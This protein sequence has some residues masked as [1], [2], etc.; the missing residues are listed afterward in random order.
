[1]SK[2]STPHSNAAVNGLAVLSIA[3]AVTLALVTAS[4]VRAQGQISS[5]KVALT[6]AT[7]QDRIDH[8]GYLRLTDEN[9]TQFI[10][11][12]D[13]QAQLARMQSLSGDC[14]NSA[15]VDATAGT[16]TEGLDT[17]PCAKI[18]S[19]HDLQSADSRI[20]SAQVAAFTAA[21]TPPVT[22]VC[23]DYTFSYSQNAS[24]T[25]SW[26]GGVGAWVNY[27]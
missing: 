23:A 5:L 15:L 7:R 1:M 11:L 10:Q 6:S 17:T 13:A 21:I 22:A 24:G 3:L 9:A 4:R 18:L 2:T 16:I 12:S 20:S 25:C 8:A 26:H 19:Q 14:V 27:P